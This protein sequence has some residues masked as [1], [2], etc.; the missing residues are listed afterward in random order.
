MIYSYPVTL[1]RRGVL[2]TMDLTAK[3][4]AFL[5]SNH[6]LRDP[7]NVVQIWL[8]RPAWT[9]LAGDDIAQPRP[10]ATWTVAEVV[11][12]FESHDAAGLGQV[13]QRNSVTG[14]DLL[15]FESS[16]GVATDLQLSPFAARKLLNLRNAHLL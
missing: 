2:V 3:N 4:F 15:A 10:V 12:F 7:R 5:R 1:A 8:S 11:A 9:S 13:L 6:W 16:Q 14:A